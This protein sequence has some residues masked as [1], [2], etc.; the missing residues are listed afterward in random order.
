MPFT[1]NTLIAVVI[2]V[3]SELLVI[4]LVLVIY[5]F[6]LIKDIRNE[7]FIKDVCTKVLIVNSLDFIQIL[8]IK[9]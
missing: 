6:D 2:D 3:C 1:L 9:D 8:L 5:C 4:N 7:L